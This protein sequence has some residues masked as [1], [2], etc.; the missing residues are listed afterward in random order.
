MT[1]QGAVTHYPY[2]IIGGGMTAVAA[3]RGIRK[4]DPDGRIGII[5]NESHPPYK[6]PFLSKALWTG[7]RLSKVWLSFDSKQVELHLSRSVTRIDRESRQVI[8]HTGAIYSYDKLLLATGGTARHLPW[9]VEGLIYFRNLD[10]YLN[11]KALAEKRDH[12]VVIGG[13]FIGSEIAAALT[14]TGRQVTM[15]FPE[16]LIGMRIYPQELAAHITACYR[17]QG[18]KVIAGDT[19][20]SITRIADRYEIRTAAGLTVHADGVVAGIG[21][22]CNTGLAAQAGLAVDNGILVDEFL[23]TA[24]ADIYAAGDVANFFNPALG[25]RM[26][27]EHEDNANVMG[28]IAG[29]NMSGERIRYHHLPFFYSDMFDLGYEAV[30]ILD[31]EMETVAVWQQPCRKGV[32]YYLDAG[33]VRGVLLCNFWGHMDQA[34][35][36]IAAPGPFDAQN[37]QTCI[38]QDPG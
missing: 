22:S 35:A 18:V 5:S 8:D 34:R 26:R 29:L 6:R 2:L 19:P 33:R 1:S 12:F 11:L 16:A 36:L 3:A 21:L 15:I 37:L 13:G 9:D 20:A 31:A 38:A 28:E 14:T 4:S 24:D 32:V 17:S 7:T 10:D 25:S 27:V 30:G 23:Q